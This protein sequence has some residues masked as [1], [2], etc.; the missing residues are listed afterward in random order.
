MTESLD[1]NCYCNHLTFQR[2]V[3]Q[4]KL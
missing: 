1:V 4:K 3:M 2:E